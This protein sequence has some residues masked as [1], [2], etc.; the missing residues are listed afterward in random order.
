LSVAEF[1]IDHRQRRR[2]DHDFSGLVGDHRTCFLPPDIDRHADNAVA[3]VTG[4]IGRGQIG[5]DA[6]RLF[7]RRFRMRENL[8]NKIDQVVD[9]Y[10]HH[11]RSL[12]LSLHP[13]GARLHRSAAIP[14][15]RAGFHDRLGRH[16]ERKIARMSTASAVIGP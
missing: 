1:A 11:V 13:R 3:V 4:Q 16:F 7:R 12:A 6:T 2:V 5:G 10:R 14:C 9:L 15:S 8:S